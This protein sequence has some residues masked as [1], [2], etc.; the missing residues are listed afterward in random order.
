MILLPNT[1]HGSSAV[2][3]VLT[4]CASFA[5]FAVAFDGI[6]PRDYWNSA[7]RFFEWE[8]LARLMR[9]KAMDMITDRE[10]MIRALR[11]GLKNPQAHAEGRRE[12][13]RDQCGYTDGRAGAR[14]AASLTRMLN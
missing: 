7:A 11:A 8:H 13:V 6:K 3:T 9:F 10:E 1:R 4:T 14:I 2:L 12:I 5:A